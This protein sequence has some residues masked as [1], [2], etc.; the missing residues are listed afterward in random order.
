MAEKQI[1]R[2]PVIDP[3]G[4]IMGIVSLADIAKNNWDSSEVGE[5]LQDI[6]EKTSGPS[7][8]RMNAKH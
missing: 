6:S 2:I 7:V 1:R 5:A 3:D 8:P 4:S